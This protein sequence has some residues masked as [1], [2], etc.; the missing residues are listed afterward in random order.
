MISSYVYNYD[1][2]CAKALTGRLVSRVSL[3]GHIVS[4]IRRRLGAATGRFIALAS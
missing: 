3:R 2:L 4:E 1:N